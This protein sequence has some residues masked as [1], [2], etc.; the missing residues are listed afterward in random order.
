MTA[1]C[2]HTERER[3]RDGYIYIYIYIYQMAAANAADP[4]ECFVRVSFKASSFA[5]RE[6]KN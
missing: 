2:V 1:S 5:A 4:E 6:V 3:E